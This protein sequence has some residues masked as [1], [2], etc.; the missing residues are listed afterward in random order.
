M[1]FLPLEEKNIKHNRKSAL[2]HARRAKEQ[3]PSANVEIF[4]SRGSVLR[5]TRGSFLTVCGGLNKET[6]YNKILINLERSVNAVRPQFDLISRTGFT[7]G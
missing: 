6:P 7:I 2:R 5:G 4:A 3:N 1:P